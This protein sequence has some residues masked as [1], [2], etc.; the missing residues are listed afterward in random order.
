MFLTSVLHLMWLAYLCREL[1]DLEAENE[2]TL[3]QINQLKEEEKSC[4]ELLER[5][6]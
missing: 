6:E 3:A 5:Y 1:S 4:Q 2:Q